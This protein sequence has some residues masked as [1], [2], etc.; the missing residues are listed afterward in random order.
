MN[1]AVFGFVFRGF[2]KQLARS[3]PKPRSGIAR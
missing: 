1:R 3:V 2:G